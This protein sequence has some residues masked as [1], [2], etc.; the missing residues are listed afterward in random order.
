[1][2]GNVP[3][4]NNQIHA[5]ILH[6]IGAGRRGT[7]D[8]CFEDG[9]ITFRD[10]AQ[11]YLR[12]SYN[13]KGYVLTI[14]SLVCSHVATK[15]GR[16]EH[17]STS[18]RHA[19]LT[20][21]QLHIATL[22]VAH[23]MIRIQV[24]WYFCP[25]NNC[26]TPRKPA[27]LIPLLFAVTPRILTSLVQYNQISLGKSGWKETDCFWC[28]ECTMMVDHAGAMFC[29]KMMNRSYRNSMKKWNLDTSMRQIMD[30]FYILAGERALQV[31]SERA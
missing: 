9:F 3:N 6:Y 2:I 19:N 17:S 27:L 21:S 7:G 14:V 22:L 29:W 4:N 26:W 24:I 18:T 16:K 31:N 10:I 13:F 12:A 23:S 15:P 20:K 28:M 8:W 1:M 11:L 25:T 5:V 30:K